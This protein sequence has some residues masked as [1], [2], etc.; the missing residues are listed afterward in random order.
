MGVFISNK[1]P[2]AAPPGACW[3]RHLSML[4]TF[5][6]LPSL[7][8]LLQRV[9]ISTEDYL[10]LHVPKT[11][12]H[13]LCSP[14]SDLSSIS[15]RWTLPGNAPF[16]SWCQKHHPLPALPL[17]SVGSSRSPLLAPP[18][19]QPT[20]PFPQPLS[21]PRQPHPVPTLHLIYVLRTPEFM[22]PALR[23]PGCRLRAGSSLTS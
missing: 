12:V 9:S 1:F 13:L 18:P 21:L 10:Y 16:F 3:E 22:L 20:Q 23:S 14:C 5:L 8:K 7:L 17:L 15:C 19:G 2:G 4:T 6:T 11:R